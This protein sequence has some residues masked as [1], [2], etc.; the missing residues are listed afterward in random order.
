MYVLSV[1]DGEGGRAGRG[2]LVEK[3]GEVEIVAGRRLERTG[4]PLF[5]A[6]LDGD[7]VAAVFAK[8]VCSNDVGS[9]GKIVRVANEVV[10]EIDSRESGVLDAGRRDFGH[11]KRVTVT[12]IEQLGR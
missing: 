12:R 6:L 8:R 3:T 10:G 4:R 11:G 7:G 1:P 5:D 2:V 9:G